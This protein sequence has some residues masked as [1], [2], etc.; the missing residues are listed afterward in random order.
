MR[1]TEIEKYDKVKSI[2]I[3]E[4]KLKLTGFFTFKKIVTEILTPDV[5]INM[6]AK[7]IEQKIDM[8]KNTEFYADTLQQYH[9]CTYDISV[10]ND[11]F[12]KAN[13]NLY[14]ILNDHVIKHNDMYLK[15]IIHVIDIIP[16]TEEKCDRIFSH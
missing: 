9:K 5:Q 8:I 11:A 1:L 13:H 10:F 15:S 2:V 14:D 6:I 12:N 7:H 4:Y 16:E 3:D